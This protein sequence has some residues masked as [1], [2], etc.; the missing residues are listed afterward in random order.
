MEKARFNVSGM[1][2]SHCE[3]AVENAL[4][5][6]GVATVKADSS[7]GKVEV[8][9]DPSVVS[10]EAIKKEIHETGYTVL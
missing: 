4:E 5:D 9:Y 8:E 6:L 7:G 10:L 1:S 3:K 2:C